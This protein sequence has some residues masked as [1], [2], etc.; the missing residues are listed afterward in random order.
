MKEYSM[1]SQCGLTL[2]Q[3]QRIYNNYGICFICEGDLSEYHIAVE[4]KEA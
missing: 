4:I 3:V 1:F 2:E